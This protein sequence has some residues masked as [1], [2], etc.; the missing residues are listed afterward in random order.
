MSSKSIVTTSIACLA[1]GACALPA[2]GPYSTN[3]LSDSKAHISGSAQQFQ[4]DAKQPKLQ[5]TLIEVNENTIG[6][7]V[8]NRTPFKKAHQ[9]PKNTAAHVTKVEVG[10]SI[11]LTIYEQNSGGLFVPKEA[12]VRPG[13]FITL[14]PQIVDQS[15]YITVPYAGQIKV[16]GKTSA[17]I[18]A[19]VTKALAD[20]ALAPQVVVSFSN[21]GGSEVSVLGDVETAS[22]F[23][24]S[25]NTQRI[26]D[27]IAAAGGPQS[28][29]YETWISLQR[30]GHEYTILMDEILL[31]PKKNIYAQPNDTIYLYSEAEVFNIYGASQVQGTLPFNKRNLTLSEALGRAQGLRDTQADPAEIYIYKEEPIEYIRAIED[32]LALDASQIE[33]DLV[34]VVY[35]INLRKT[36]GFFFAQKFPVQDQ[37]VVYIANAETVEYLKFLNIISSTSSTKSVTKGAF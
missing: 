27:V 30:D 26:L 33:G 13:N 6:A 2:S 22:R 18:S 37:D 12:G 16:A 1:L 8:Q 28:P 36:E 4:G 20:L 31:D 9:W 24:L 35:K 10:D 34:P 19:N 25:F 29:G 5:Y 21:R 15:G 11:Q 7:I 14:P 23:S 3:M 32:S 17:E